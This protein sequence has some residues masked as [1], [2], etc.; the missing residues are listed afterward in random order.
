V[1]FVVKLAVTISVLV[2]R[3]I[4]RHQ[5]LECPTI[6][7]NGGLL[8]LLSFPVKRRSLSRAPYKSSHAYIGQIAFDDDVK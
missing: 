1:L 5:S 8:S 2:A 3:I 7:Q 4:H 6:G